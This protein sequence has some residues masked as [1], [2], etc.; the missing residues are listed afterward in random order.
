MLQ[1]VGDNPWGGIASFKDICMHEHCFDPAAGNDA[2][3]P[4]ISAAAAAAAARCSSFRFCNCCCWFL[5][6]PPLPSRST[7][8]DSRI[9]ALLRLGPTVQVQPF[10]ALLRLLLCRVHWEGSGI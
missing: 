2:A 9:G 8:Q 10:A 7:H 6:R 1:A 3:V 5:R 4:V